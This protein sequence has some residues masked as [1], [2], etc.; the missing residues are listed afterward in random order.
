M[1][2]EYTNGA[3]K[4]VVGKGY[5]HNSIFLTKYFSAVLTSLAL[6][7]AIIIV[8]VL[9][10]VAVMGTARIGDTFL[11]D[12]L[13]YVGVQLMLDVAYSGMIATISELTSCK[14]QATDEA[15][16]Y[17]TDCVKLLTN[18]TFSDIIV[19]KKIQYNTWVL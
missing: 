15:R 12:C 17:V 18:Q 11:P 1:V 14:I 4:N 5:S 6:D 19:L 8:A 9:A 7:I 10:G 3:V 2:G 13:A 16:D